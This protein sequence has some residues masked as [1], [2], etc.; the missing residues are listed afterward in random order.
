IE[1]YDLKGHLLGAGR[2]YLELIA[3]APREEVHDQFGDNWPA[4]LDR[5]T[6]LWQPPAAPPS[7]PEAPFKPGQAV[8][9]YYGNGLIW[10]PATIKQAQLDKVEVEFD[11]HLREWVPVNLV[12]EKYG[13]GQEDWPRPT[14][15]MAAVK[16]GDRVEFLSQG[17]TIY[18]PATVL[19]RRGSRLR[20]RRDDDTEEWT[21]PGLC[22]PPTPD[23]PEPEPPFAVGD[24]VDFRWLGST[25]IYKGWIAER[26]GDR[27]RIEVED[28]TEEWTTIG[29]CRRATDPDEDAGDFPEFAVGDRVDCRY[30]GGRKYYPGKMTNRRGNRM[31]VAYDDGS[32]GGTTPRLCRKPKEETGKSAG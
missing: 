13:S 16:P 6:T 15:E 7:E 8:Q 22:R 17:D 31:L 21:M 3:W 25:A 30:Q 9:C 29:K 5:S 1:V 24:Y 26:Q 2:T 4:A 23:E 28:G 10:F 27:L 12:R 19:E 20:V 11:D 32:N 14:P 18:F